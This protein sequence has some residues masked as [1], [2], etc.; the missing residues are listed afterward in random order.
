MPNTYTAYLG[1]IGHESAAK[2]RRFDAPRGRAFFSRR[3]RRRRR[4]SR[5]IFSVAER[6][7][8]A[9]MQA[10]RERVGNVHG[11]ASIRRFIANEIARMQRH[12]STAT[13]R[14]C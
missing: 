11:A 3:R 1:I 12:V 9:F 10:R 13:K 5:S 7:R 2:K 4:C 14:E 8:A 6:V